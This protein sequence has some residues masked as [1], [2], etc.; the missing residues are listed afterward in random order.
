LTGLSASTSCRADDE[1]SLDVG[2][3]RQF[4]AAPQ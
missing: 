4:G 1:V 2:C 3:W